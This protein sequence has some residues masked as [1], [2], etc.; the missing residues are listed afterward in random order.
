MTVPPDRQPASAG[1][2]TIGQLARY[3]GVTVRAIRHYHQRGLLPEPGRD[4]SGYRRYDARAALDLIRIKVLAE[5]G[6]PLARISELL[7]AGPEQLAGSVARI[8]QDLRRQISELQRRRRRIAELAGGEDAFLPAELAGLLAE[9]RAVGVSDRAVRVERDGWILLLA[10]Y[11]QR[12][13]VWLGHKR[14]DLADPEFQRLYLGCDEAAGWDPAD[15]R[16]ETL[17]DAM[18]RYLRR[19]RAG[20]GD[21]PDVTIDDPALAALLTSYFGSTSSPSMARLARLAEEKLG[22]VADVAADNYCQ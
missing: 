12:A 2:L 5:A 19:R 17:A 6:V 21:L 11:P 13:L 3:A 8:D 9:L 18:V 14:A 22:T 16:L 4:A 7:G 20:Q 1:M 10:R 15:P